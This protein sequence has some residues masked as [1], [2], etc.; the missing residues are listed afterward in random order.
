[1]AIQSQCITC[2][3]YDSADFC[4]AR[5]ESIVYDGYP[6]YETKSRAY[7][8]NENEQELDNPQNRKISG[9]LTFF[10]VV[11][12][13]G[14]ILT[15]VIG[16]LNMSIFNYDIGTGVLWTWIGVVCDS[17]FLLGIA[18]LAVYTIIS[19]I[20]YKPNAVGLGKAYLIIVLVSNVFSLILGDYESTGINSMSQISYRI[21][22]QVIWLFYLSH[23]K[24]VNALFPKAKRKLSI[25]DIT[26]LS[27]IVAP[28]LIWFMSSFLFSF[29]QS[30]FDGL[31]N[32]DHI[33]NEYTL[34]TNEY[35][36][37]R[38]IFECPDGLTVEKLYDK[39]DEDDIY[40]TLYN[41]DISVTICSAY[42]DTNTYAYFEECMQDW[43]DESLDEYEHAITEDTQNYSFGNSIFRK[44]VQYQIDPPIKWTFALIFNDETSKCCLI[45]YYCTEDTH[46]L[47][48]LINSIR[49][50]Q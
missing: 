49:F 4:T 7:A 36:D 33:I 43:A 1:M 8:S 48:E 22:W 13:L 10:L 45:S 9:W 44:T 21:I 32:D 11:I 15:P 26:M 19:F 16:F 38:I 34:S 40:Y 18:F 23:S 42:E 37:S 17:L 24:Q 29:G 6:C 30:F 25:S 50:K 41:E 31:L 20:N 2:K 39:Y 14:G 35:T 3:Y 28:V 46:H 47:N 5:R 27:T 12:G